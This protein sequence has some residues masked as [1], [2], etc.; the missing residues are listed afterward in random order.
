MDNIVSK[1][2]S[3]VSSEDASITKGQTIIQLKDPIEHEHGPE[4]AV[5]KMR[6]CDHKVFNRLFHRE[7]RRSSF[8][9]MDWE[10]TTSPRLTRPGVPPAQPSTPPPSSG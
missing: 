2:T 3:F 1:S 4:I 7:A 5:V 8:E 6:K 10:V 9:P